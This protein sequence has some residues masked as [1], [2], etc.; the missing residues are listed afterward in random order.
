MS[1]KHSIEGSIPSRRS[2]LEKEILMIVWLLGPCTIS[3]LVDCLVKPEE[4]YDI[5]Y[6]RNKEIRSRCVHLLD[7]GKL[8]VT[9]ELQL[10]LG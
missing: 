4:L 1:A 5:T 6:N 2:K 3:Q 10:K 8:A 7:Q 9:K